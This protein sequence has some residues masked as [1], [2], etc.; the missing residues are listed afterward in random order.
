M[1]R[2]ASPAPTLAFGNAAECRIWMDTAPFTDLAQA[3][4]LLLQ[5]VQLLGRGALNAAERLDILELLRGPIDEMQEEFSHRFAGKALPLP[6]ADQAAFDACRALWHA[7]AAGYMRC[8]EAIFA[9]EAGMKSK[10]ALVLQRAL[11]TLVAEQFETHR[12]GQIPSGE[13]WRMLHQLYASAEQ[14]NVAGQEVMDSARLG[15]TPGSAAAT[16]VEGILLG[17][18]NLHEQ[19]PRQLAWIARWARRWAAKVRILAAPPTLTTNAIPLCVDLGSDRPA[20]YMPLDTVG[21][22]WLETAE[23]ARSLKKRLRLLEKGEPPAK[24]NLGEDCTQPACEQLLRQAYQRWCRGGAIR[25]FE[26]RPASGTLRFIAGAEAIHYYLSERKPFQESGASD[27]EQ[28][29]RE[30]EEMATFGR[31]ATHRNE[32]FSEQHGYA[33]EQWQALENWH[34][35]DT[36]VA[37]MRITR[38]TAQSGARIA[39]G[40]LIAARPADAQHFLLGSVRWALVSENL[41]VGLNLFPGQPEPVSVR[42]AGAAAARDKFRPAFLLPAVPA[43]KQEASIVM[44]V[45]TFKLGKSVEIFTGQSR[46]LRLLRLVERGVD[47]E[48]AT[49]ETA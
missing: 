1:S 15:K 2:P 35:V 40:Q 7:L 9:G 17:A 43:V 16:Y 38:P 5:Q 18:A 8:A 4:A 26:R 45:G 6:P 13:H 29:R 3:H 20:G 39:L 48:R 37:G 42:N 12:A 47:F 27:M 44:P 32:G 46:R 28:L 41:Q 34:M 14:L 22:R 21:A 19:N 30:R 11:A 31:I 10:A 23:L 33:I 36:S 49:Y 25:G 24:L